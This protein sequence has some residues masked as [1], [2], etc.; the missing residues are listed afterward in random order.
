MRRPAYWQQCIAA[1]LVQFIAILPT[2]A[3]APA[4]SSLPATVEEVNQKLVKLFGSGGFRGVA[5]Y[6]TGILVSPDGYILTV[7]GPLLETRDLRVHLYDGRRFHAKVVVSEPQLD[8]ALVKIDKV[9]D[10]PHFDVAQA[11]QNPLAKAGDSILAF[12]N[13][14]EIATRDD[15]VSVTHGVIAAYTKLH[16]RRGVFEATYQGDVYL[17]DAVTNNPGAGGGALTTRKG[18][19]LGLIG[20]EL[21]NTLSD[22]WVNYAVPIQALARFVEQAK[23]GVY[24]PLVREKAIAG[25][26][27]FHGIVLVPD[28]VD[29]TP[30]FVEEVLPG[31]PAAKAGLKPDD[32]IV[33]VDGEKIG[34]VKDFRE[35]VD[36]A[37]PGTLFRV[38]VRRGD[39][40]TTVELRVEPP[41]RKE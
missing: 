12:S 5:A 6:G 18:E 4:G 13:Q 23:G 17:V 14:F 24:K 28:V 1:V 22:T 16:G 7:A 32:L 37:L 15:P 33:Y 26:R 41:P 19:L 2:Q 34:S 21:R 38:E 35:M 36:K 10:L 25:L 3:Q 39:K 40:L 8:V 20:K 31:S 11:A 30:A 27:C 29:R 9:E